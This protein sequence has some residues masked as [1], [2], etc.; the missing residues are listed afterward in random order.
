MLN[1][2]YETTLPYDYEIIFLRRHA[3][4]IPDLEAK[5]SDARPW[6]PV[7]GSYEGKVSGR[8]QEV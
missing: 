6:D 8:P 1:V 5:A 3:S 2:S 4:N 7:Q